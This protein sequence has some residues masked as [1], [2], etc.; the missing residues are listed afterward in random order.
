MNYS[1]SKEIDFRG[2]LD[3]QHHK[4]DKTSG[5]NVALDL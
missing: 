5:V 1:L 3:S 4:C 2:G